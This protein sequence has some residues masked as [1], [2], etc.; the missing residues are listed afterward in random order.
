M[1][2]R[3]PAPVLAVVVVGTGIALAA[4]PRGFLARL[5]LVV[6]QHISSLCTEGQRAEVRGWSWSIPRSAECREGMEELMGRG[7]ELRPHARKAQQDHIFTGRRHAWC[8]C[9]V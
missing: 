4:Q 1:L 2:P 3:T 6:P 7:P 5:R 8:V 9:V